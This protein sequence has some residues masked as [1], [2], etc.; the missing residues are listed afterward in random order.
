[1]LPRRAAHARQR[2]V[3]HKQ[4]TP[5]TGS[6]HL[7]TGYLQGASCQV[8]QCSTGLLTGGWGAECC[9]ATLVTRCRGWAGAAAKWQVQHGS[10]LQQC[11]P[12]VSAPGPAGASVQAAFPPAELGR[13][14]E[15]SHL[16]Q[17]GHYA[18]R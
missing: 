10:K 18:V 4:Y 16:P 15:R 8:G 12:A 5:A 6:E 14:A 11:R 3:L 1:M 9:S 2:A 17:A 7:I 13:L